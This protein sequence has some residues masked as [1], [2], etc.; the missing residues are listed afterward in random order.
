MK[1][2]RRQR[3]Q[4]RKTWLEEHWRHVVAAVV[5]GFFFGWWYGNARNAGGAEVNSNKKFAVNACERY[6]GLNG[7]VLV[8]HNRISGWQY[9]SVCTDGKGRYWLAGV[10]DPNGPL[11]GESP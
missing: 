11:P 2:Q 7:A 9:E 1:E 6:S 10:D 4:E 8:E 3:W 5:V